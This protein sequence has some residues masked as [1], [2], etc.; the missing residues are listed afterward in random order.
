MVLVVRILLERVEQSDLHLLVRGQRL[1]RVISVSILPLNLI[2]DSLDL[3]GLVHLGHVF[4]LFAVGNPVGLH[5]VSVS[6]ERVLPEQVVLRVVSLGLAGLLQQ[7]LGRLPVLGGCLRVE[8]PLVEQTADVVELRLAVR[9]LD[10]SL[11]DAVAISTVVHVVVH[12]GD[13]SLH[14][15][16]VCL[17]NVKVVAQLVG[18]ELEHFQF[19]VDVVVPLSLEQVQ[20]DL[21]GGGLNSGGFS[22]SHN[23]L[24]VLL[25]GLVE[26]QDFAELLGQVGVLS[27]VL[28]D[29]GYWRESV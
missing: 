1:S 5:C 2:E 13:S 25:L 3:L 9:V 20:L 24:Q 7:M 21:V 19:L 4:V 18:G 17:G 22:I 28:H 14:P 12:V 15:R 16:V 23:L 29:H 10:E 11:T 27:Q 6:D 26:V 8:D